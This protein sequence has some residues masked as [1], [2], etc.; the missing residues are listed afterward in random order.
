MKERRRNK[1]SCD[2]MWNITFNSFPK[3]PISTGSCESQCFL[4][5]GWSGWWDKSWMTRI[6]WQRL[7]GVW[8]NNQVINEIT[9]ER[10]DRPVIQFEMFNNSGLHRNKM[11]LQIINDKDKNTKSDQPLSSDLYFYAAPHCGDPIRGTFSSF[12]LTLWES[13]LTHQHVESPRRFNAFSRTLE[14]HC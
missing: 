14:I 11:A 7:P 6:M 9:E 8:G 12:S 4:I 5:Q 10:K 3:N 13:V 1:N 2:R